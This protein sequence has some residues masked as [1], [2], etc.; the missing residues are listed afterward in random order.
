MHTLI[1]VMWGDTKTANRP[2]QCYQCDHF[3]KPTARITY[4]NRIIYFDRFWIVLYHVSFQFWRMCCYEITLSAIQRML[5][6]SWLKPPNVTFL[7]FH[8]VDLN[9]V[10]CLNVLFQKFCTFQ[11]FITDIALDFAP[12]FINVLFQVM[13]PS[14]DN[15]AIFTFKFPKFPTLFLVTGSTVVGDSFLTVFA[16]NFPVRFHV[17]PQLC[18]S[19]TFFLTLLTGENTIVMLCFNMHF[20][21]FFRGCFNFAD[22][23]SRHL[24]FY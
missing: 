22:G 20:Q 24:D 2:Y 11:R 13:F 12:V 16:C 23:A 9:S 10:S 6:L 7:G 21:M 3:C 8:N 17:C 19:N 4:L 1:L 15:R 5:K 14:E 18:P